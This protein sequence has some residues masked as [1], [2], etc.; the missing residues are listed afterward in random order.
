MEWESVGKYFL[1][2]GELDGDFS[3]RKTMSAS[4]RGRILKQSMAR[5][6]L[7]LDSFPFPVAI[8]V[9]ARLPVGF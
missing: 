3:G 8:Y 5:E 6:G 2:H 4:K 1:D 9:L 7:T